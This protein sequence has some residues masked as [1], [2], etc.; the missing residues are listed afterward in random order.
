MCEDLY[1]T[2]GSPLCYRFMNALYS[3][4]DGSSDN[5]KFED[6]CRAIIGIQSYVLFTLDKLI[7]KLVK[8]VK[9]ISSSFCLL[10]TIISFLPLKYLF[11]LFQLQAVAADEMDTKLLQLYAYEKSRKPG[12][13]VDMVYHENARVLLHDENIYRIE[14]VSF[15][16]T[17]QS[18]LV[19][20]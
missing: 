10:H 9:Y 6:D 14:Y 12:K 13:F 19:C 20:S 1:K 18:T 7:Y 8:Q 17:F 16:F 11:I 5:T 2:E 3:L 4:L 15:Y